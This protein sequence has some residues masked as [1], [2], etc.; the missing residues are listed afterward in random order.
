MFS[1]ILFCNM[2]ANFQIIFFAAPSYKKISLMLRIRNTLKFER[3]F[4]IFIVAIS[5]D[6]FSR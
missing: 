5:K 3:K 1:V 2:Y 6:I 4:F